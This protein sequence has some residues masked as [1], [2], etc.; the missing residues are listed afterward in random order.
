VF[1][2]HF[3]I[4]DANVIKFVFF[5]FVGLKSKYKCDDVDSVTHMRVLIYQK[6]ILCVNIH[7]F[8]NLF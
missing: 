4:V 6:T 5:C 3:G 7:L 2:I 8:S 1:F